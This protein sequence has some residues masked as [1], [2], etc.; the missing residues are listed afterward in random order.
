MRQM[1]R[2]D[3]NVY[4]YECTTVHMSVHV[5]CVNSFSF[6]SFPFSLVHEELMSPSLSPGK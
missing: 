3:Q 6:S 4:V 5:V 2:P 1:V